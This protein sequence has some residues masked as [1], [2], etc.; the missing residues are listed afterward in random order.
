MERNDRT[1]VKR[2]YEKVD[3][4]RRNPGRY[5]EKLF[6]YRFYRPRI[7][8]FLFILDV[9]SRVLIVLI[10]KVGNRSASA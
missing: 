3:Q 8:N 1:I 9:Q 2:I 4:L 7:G 5:V 10:L 6:S